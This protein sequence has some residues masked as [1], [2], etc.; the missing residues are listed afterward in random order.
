MGRY[1]AMTL[2]KQTGV[3]GLIYCGYNAPVC[4]DL[5]KPSPGGFKINQ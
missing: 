1:T 2:Q 5:N 3:L 4:F